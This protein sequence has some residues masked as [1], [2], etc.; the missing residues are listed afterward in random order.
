MLPL[1][2]EASS[3]HIVTWNTD[4]VQRST[5]GRLGA[6]QNSVR[7]YEYV[8]F[9][10]SHYSFLHAALGERK[11]FTNG[12]HRHLESSKQAQ[13]YNTPEYLM[14]LTRLRRLSPLPPTLPRMSHFSRHP[15]LP[16][17]TPLLRTSPPPAI[18]EYAVR[19]ACLGRYPSLVWLLLFPPAGAQS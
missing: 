17:G 10:T 4:P 2:I 16:Q 3:I 1:S 18:P 19:R 15:L 6:G 12:Q 11:R 13:H 14:Q 7:H 5:S 8:S 9:T